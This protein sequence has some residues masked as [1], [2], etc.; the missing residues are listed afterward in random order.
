M[1]GDGNFYEYKW[2]PQRIKCQMAM[3]SKHTDLHK[4]VNTQWYL[5]HTQ[6]FVCVPV[7]SCPF[8]LRNASQFKN[9]SKVVWRLTISPAHTCVSN[10]T[11]SV[12]FRGR[13]Q[14][15]SVFRKS[16]RKLQNCHPLSSWVG[17]FIWNHSFHVIEIHLNFIWNTPEDVQLEFQLEWQ[18]D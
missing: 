13:N 4:P 5:S 10:R 9:S 16:C 6:V 14:S 7:L 17:I 15:C 2:I 1:I 18:E 12:C 11:K 3:L 8:I